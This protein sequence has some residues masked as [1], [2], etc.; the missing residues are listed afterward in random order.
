METAIVRTTLNILLTLLIIGIGACP[1]RAADPVEVVII[2]LEGEALENVKAVLSLPSGLVRD[3]R[4]NLPWLQRF[5]EEI[6]EKAREALEPF[7]YYDAKVGTTLQNPEKNEYRILVG[8]FPGRPVLIKEIS[9]R[10]RGAGAEEQA[11]KDLVAAFPL[12]RGEVLN[13]SSYEKGKEL[14]KAKAVELGYLEA[15]YPAHEIRVSRGEASARIALELDTGVRYS[16]GRTTFSGAPQYPQPFLERY[17]DYKPGETF[18]QQKLGQ[19]QLNLATSDRFKGVVVTRDRR[20]ARDAVM[21]VMVEL[22]PLP[23]RRLRPGIGYGTDTGVRGTVKYKDVNLFLL[24][25]ELNAEINVSERLQGI[26]AGYVAPSYRDI[27]SSMGLQFNLQRE[28]TDTYTTSLASLEGNVNRSFLRGQVGTVYLKL[29]QEN[30]TINL[31]ETKTFLVLPGL[32]FS[33]RRFD[34]PLRPTLGYRYDLEA[35]GTHQSIGS[36]I[37]FIQFIAEGRVIVPLPWRFSLIS[38]AKGG[39]TIQDDPLRDMPASLRFFAGG[40]RS[41]R[42]YAYQS[43][44]PKD[45]TGKVVGGKNLLTASLELERALFKDWGV[46]AF[47]DIG[48]AFNSLSDVRLYKG[49]GV[50]ARY[51]TPI[52]ALQLD[53]ARQIGVDNPSFRIHFTVGFEL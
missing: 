39:V 1:V 52:G 26:A 36:G 4:V 22:S 50:G 13:H 7:G 5:Q 23:R 12:R 29:Q 30:S 11:V 20:N 14:L 21:P 6:P 40:D 17:L 10:V 2:G 8:V 53:V 47:F 35:R 38:R 18:S 37:S 42:G 25:H 32:R 3:G 44:G 24:G 45:V 9:V 49:A 46:A 33:H 27:N 41:V 28:E 48:N 34:N 51:Y 19:T 16:F 15:D 31:Q 43:L